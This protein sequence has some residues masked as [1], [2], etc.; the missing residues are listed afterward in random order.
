MRVPPGGRT[1]LSAGGAG[2]QGMDLPAWQDP[3]SPWGGPLASGRRLGPSG[4]RT[5]RGSWGGW[6]AWESRLDG[7]RRPERE[8]LCQPPGVSV[9]S[10]KT[11]AA[12][13]AQAC[14]QPGKAPNTGSLAPW[15]QGGNEG[16]ALRLAGHPGLADHPP[17]PPGTLSKAAPVRG[18]ASRLA[19]FWLVIQAAGAASL[20]S[21]PEM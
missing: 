2:I 19:P 1:T 5:G 7:H 20:G 18:G 11:F 16:S 10:W 21:L 17:L 4:W 12:P 9:D 8:R 15:W 3:W 6:Q 13:W 14:L